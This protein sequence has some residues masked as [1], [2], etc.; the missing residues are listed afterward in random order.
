MKTFEVN[1]MDPFVRGF[2][3]L[4]MDNHLNDIEIQNLK[5]ITR[6]FD[7]QVKSR[8]DVQLGFLIGYSYAKLVMQF[9]I[10]K[11]RLPTKEDIEGFFGLMKK[12]HP[13]IIS[14]LKEVS[15]AKIAD[16]D[17]M[18]VPIKEIDVDPLE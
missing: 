2:N 17:E 14:A 3:E 18:L 16:K 4:L 13:E 10:L 11:N 1:T 9:L 7:K 5:G 12:R 15:V 6:I 8:M